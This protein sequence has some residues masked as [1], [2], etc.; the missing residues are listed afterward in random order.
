VAQGDSVIAFGICPIIGFV[1]PCNVACVAQ[2]VKVSSVQ[3][4]NL[5]NKFGIV[6]LGC[7]LAT[8]PLYEVPL[9]QCFL[10]K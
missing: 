8:T 1:L 2:F 4:I 5:I 9:G 7:A 10:K 3:I 6:V